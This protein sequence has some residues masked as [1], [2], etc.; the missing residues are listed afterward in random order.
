MP[1][2]ADHLSFLFPS[3]K[4]LFKRGKEKVFERTAPAADVDRLKDL[5]GTTLMRQAMWTLGLGSFFP[6]IDTARSLAA[7]FGELK[8]EI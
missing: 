3:Y 6:N 8:L 5:S 1:R 2:K 4:G 7:E